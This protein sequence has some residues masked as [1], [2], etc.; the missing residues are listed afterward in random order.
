MSPFAKKMPFPFS[1]LHAA[2]VLLIFH[3]VGIVGILSKYSSFFVALTPMNLLLS[4]FILLAFHPKYDSRFW[5]FSIVTILSGIGVEWIGVHTGWLFGSYS[6]SG[7]FGWRL[8][9]IPVLI[10]L[11]WLMLTIISGEVL[12]LIIKNKALKIIASAALMVFID[13]LIEPVAV[14]YNFWQWHTGFIPWTN[15][16]TWFA[17]SIPLQFLYSWSRRGN[18]PLAKWLILVQILFFIA[19][20]IK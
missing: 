8:D 19:L 12:H 4:M 18:N 17:V 1:E 14:K 2:I 11:N 5:I 10:G 16:A 15:Y 7:V 20:Q 6:Y 3:F 13:Y 9:G